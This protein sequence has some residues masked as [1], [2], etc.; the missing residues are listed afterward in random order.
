MNGCSEVEYVDDLP[1][2]K[3]VVPLQAEEVHADPVTQLWKVSYH[4]R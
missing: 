1:V 3:E 2:S 4:L